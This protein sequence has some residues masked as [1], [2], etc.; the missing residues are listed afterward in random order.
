MKKNDYS[1]T[2]KKVGTGRYFWDF[3]NNTIKTLDRDLTVKAIS[4]NNVY[5]RWEFKYR[6]AEKPDIDS[7][8]I[9][10]MQVMTPNV[11][12][13]V[14]L[15]Y[16]TQEEQTELGVVEGSAYYL[17]YFDPSSI[18]VEEE[19][20]VEMLPLHPNGLLYDGVT[21]YSENA[22]IPALTDFT[23]IA[24]RV[25]MN[26][27]NPMNECFIHKG[28]VSTPISESALMLEYEIGNDTYYRSSSYGGYIN[29]ERSNRPEIITYQTTESYNRISIIKGS[30]IDTQGLVV[31]AVTNNYWKGVFYKLILYP[32]TIPLLQI[33]FLKN[34]MEKDEI[35]DLTNPI[36]IKDE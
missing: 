20:T 4:N 24:K 1:F 2:A 28:V 12:I 34:L 21:D 15:P 17:F 18:P 19:Y 7:T 26:K 16:K 30:G 9:L 36:F 14:T 22:N 11:P 35:I 6:T 13:T 29:I 3:K 25:W 27:D 10:L 8:I 23:V 5:I 32:K 33:N 31:G